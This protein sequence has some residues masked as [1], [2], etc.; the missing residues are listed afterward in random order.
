MAKSQLEKQIEKQ[1]KQAKQLAD[2]Q[3]RE[4]KRMERQAKMRNTASSIVSGQPMVEGIRIMDKTAEEVLQCLLKC[5]RGTSN[6]ISYQDDIFPEYVQWSIGVE[7][8]KLIQYGMIGSRISYDN[9][10]LLHLLPPALTY[11][12]DK[13]NA[14][15]E[16][17]KKQT[18]SNIQSIVNYGNYICGNVTN[19]TLSVD[20]SIHEIEKTIEEQGGE[21]KEE[22]YE[23]MEDVKELLENIK[24]SRNIPKQ[25]KL[26]E[27]LSNHMEKHG[28]FYG[29][30]VQLLGTAILHMMG[31]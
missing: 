27:R 8:E 15:K 13:E 12:E 17:E 29:A 25:R 18:N 1:M 23:I 26:F 19:S 31:A 4:E 30:I 9:G 24:T 28:W 7:L 10:G 21:D 6:R 14:L 2:K 11:F 20:N 22:L 16:H 5:E 3:A